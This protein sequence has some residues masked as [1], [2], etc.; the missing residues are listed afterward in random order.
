VLIVRVVIDENGSIIGGIVV[1]RRK[2]D[3]SKRIIPQ[4]HSVHHRFIEYPGI[5]PRSLW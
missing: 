4:Y 1:G 2:P 3:Y 5:E